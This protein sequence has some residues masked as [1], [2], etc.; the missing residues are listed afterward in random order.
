MGRIDEDHALDA[1]EETW[2]ALPA[3][4][5]EASE[6]YLWSYAVLGQVSLT[7]ERAQ[8]MVASLGAARRLTELARN[9]DMLERA[10]P[11]LPI[12]HHLVAGRRLVRSLSDGLILLSGIRHPDDLAL[13][14]LIS[15]FDLRA[16]LER[17]STRRWLSGPP[18]PLL[19]A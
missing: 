9:T 12:V 8:A 7:Q 19:G 2:A 4:I 5:T 13:L 10:A 11:Q 6:I 18:P 1:A 16:E 15:P 17:E 14:P 3:L